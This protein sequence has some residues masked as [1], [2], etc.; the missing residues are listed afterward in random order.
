MGALTGE[1]GAAAVVVA[2]VDL[3]LVVAA[4]FG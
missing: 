4:G 3:A 2:G 1:E